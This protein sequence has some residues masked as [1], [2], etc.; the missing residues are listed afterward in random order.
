MSTQKDILLETIELHDYRDMRPTQSN[1]ALLLRE[2]DMLEFLG[3]IGM[4]RISHADREMWKP[5]TSA[6]FHAAM[7]FK[8]VLQFHARRK[9]PKSVLREW[10]KAY[11]GSKR[12]VLK[13]YESDC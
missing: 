9:S 10:T 7:T 8:G 11:T 3:L 6:S 13:P 4:A 12:K 1:E 2:A 5:V